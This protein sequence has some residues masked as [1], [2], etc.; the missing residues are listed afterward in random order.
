MQLV[1]DSNIVIAALISPEG[2]TNNLLCSPKLECVAPEF[3]EEE[4]GKYFPLIVRKSGLSEKDIR[5]GLELLLSQINIFSSGEYENFREKA[6]RISPDPKD[7]EYIA[8]ALSL[9]CHLWSN[10]KILKSQKE[11]KVFSTSELLQ[12]L[13]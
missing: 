9:N 6:G 5:L 1:V 4:I 2:I 7:V 8:V 13:S 12:F 11:V 3:I 10:D